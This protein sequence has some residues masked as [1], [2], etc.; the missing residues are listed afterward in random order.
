MSE[1]IA[2]VKSM[3]LEPGGQELVFKVYLRLKDRQDKTE[4]E[5]M[6]LHAI[7]LVLHR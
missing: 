6:R 1:Y 3:L 7:E 2:A 5:V 4:E